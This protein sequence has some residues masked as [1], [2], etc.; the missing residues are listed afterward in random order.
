MKYYTFL[1]GG[2]GEYAKDTTVLAVVKL[3]DNDDIKSYIVRLFFKY[4]KY[5]DI[6]SYDHYKSN[7]YSTRIQKI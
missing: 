5:D 4:C 6:G 3:K 7:V 2:L 1:E